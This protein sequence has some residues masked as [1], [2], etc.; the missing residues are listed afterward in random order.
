VLQFR[1]GHD[2]TGLCV[3][4]FLLFFSSQE[5]EFA[6]LFG[7]AGSL[8][9]NFHTGRQLACYHFHDRDLAYERVNDSL[10]YKSRRSC[11]YDTHFL[12]LF[13]VVVKAFICSVLQRCRY[14][15]H[16]QIQQTFNT[17]SQ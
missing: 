10:K 3:I 17:V 12:H 6:Q 5:E 7:F 2:V 1:N 9:Q 13:I 8:I 11:I 15:S 4:E 16:Q 14:I